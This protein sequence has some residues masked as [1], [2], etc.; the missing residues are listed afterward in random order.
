MLQSLP[1]PRAFAQYP[2]GQPSARLSRTSPRSP[3]GLSPP[4]CVAGCQN[5]SI[6]RGWPPLRSCDKLTPRTA[7]YGIDLESVRNHSRSSRPAPARPA[8][9]GKAPA[10]RLS[11]KGRPRPCAAPLPHRASAQDCLSDAKCLGQEGH[12][13]LTNCILAPCHDRILPQFFAMPGRRGSAA[14]GTRGSA[15]QAD[16]E[17]VC[18]LVHA[19]HVR[20]RQPWALWDIHCLCCSSTQRY[21]PPQ[22]SLNAD[23]SKRLACGMQHPAG[24]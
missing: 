13:I 4:A 1:N 6:L 21:P 20:E 16:N 23:L 9:P 8:A 12:E 17:V 15:Q 10:A 14:Q 2:K 3:T 22:H 24:A 7:R 11:P 19:I 18:T 5:E